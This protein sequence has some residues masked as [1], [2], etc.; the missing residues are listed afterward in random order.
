MHPEGKGFVRQDFG[1]STKRF[2][3]MRRVPF[4]YSKPFLHIP[5]INVRPQTGAFF[6]FA[7]TFRAT[8]GRGGSQSCER[9]I[10]DFQDVSSEM[11]CGHS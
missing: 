1:N 11:A 4:P 3:R 2:A 5:F 9:E 10:R 6:L 7:L 8:Q